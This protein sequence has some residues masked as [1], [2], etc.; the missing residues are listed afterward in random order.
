MPLPVPLELILLLGLT[1]E[2]T[3]PGRSL[4]IGLPMTGLALEILVLLETVVLSL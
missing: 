2:L 4:P 3:L 1:L